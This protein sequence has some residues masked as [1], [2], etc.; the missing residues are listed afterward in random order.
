MTK[1][2][3]ILRERRVLKR[4]RR[5]WWQTFARETRCKKCGYRM[6]VHPHVTCDVH[7][8][9]QEWRTFKDCN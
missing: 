9:P 4:I 1:R 6:F 7:W 5:W 3:E 2:E 8:S